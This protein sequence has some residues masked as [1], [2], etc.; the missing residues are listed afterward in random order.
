MARNPKDPWWPARKAD[1]RI[2]MVNYPAKMLL[3]QDELVI[4]TDE[5]TQADDDSAMFIYLLDYIEDV[6]LYLKELTVYE[7][8]VL[9]G[10]SQAVIGAPPVCPTLTVP[11]SVVRG[12]LNR[13]FA[14][15]TN[16]KKR[17]GYNTSI[18]TGLKIIGADIAPFNED[19]Y[20]ANGKVKVNEN[21]FKFTFVKGPFI[22]GMAISQ[23][24]GTDPAFYEIARVTVNG[25]LL[26]TL[27]LEAG[28]ETRNFKMK[29]FIGNTLVG[30]SSPVFSA[31]WTSPPPPL[32]LSDA[33]KE[34]AAKEAK[35]PPAAE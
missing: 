3:Y 22:T 26:N 21:G 2:W 7:N 27:N 8:N 1:Q 31:T 18:G 12:M 9:S 6:R 17:A 23:Q 16:L 5:L 29:A 13:T 30:N 32:P 10:A 28:P 33:A 4:T 24:R 15:M 14:L 11:L 19:T 35:S 34:V 20:I 25:F